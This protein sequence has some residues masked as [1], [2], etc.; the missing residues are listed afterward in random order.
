M[1]LSYFILKRE[2][3]DLNERDH[4]EDDFFR[5]ITR[6]KTDYREIPL[7]LDV[8]GFYLVDEDKQDYIVINNL[9]PNAEKLRSQFHEGCHLC[10]DHPIEDEIVLLFRSLEPIKRRAD[11]TAEALSLI[12]MFSYPTLERYIRTG[13]LPEHLFPYVEERLH[14]LDSNGI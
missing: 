4:C 7:D 8:S 1:L 6:K 11:I 10:L 3:P 14:I 9:L 13:Y 2:F 12:L 5:L